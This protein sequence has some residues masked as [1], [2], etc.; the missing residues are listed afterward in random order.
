MRAAVPESRAGAG[1]F[2]LLAA[3]VFLLAVLAARAL[4]AGDLGWTLF[5]LGLP[6][7][8]LL[9][10]LA[11][12]WGL[13]FVLLGFFTTAVLCLRIV[14]VEPRVSWPYLLL[15]PLA[16]AGGALAYK[17]VRGLLSLRKA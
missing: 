16:L 10:R 13:A 5:A 8:L 7:L 9:L 3:A 6:L 11:T 1:R 12:T 14:L 15:A 2:V 4:L 17:V